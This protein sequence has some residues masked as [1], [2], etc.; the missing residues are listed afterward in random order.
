MPNRGPLRPTDPVS[1][2]I[3]RTIGSTTRPC[4]RTASVI[5]IAPCRPGRRIRRRRSKVA[6]STTTRSGN[7]STTCRQASTGA[8][9]ASSRP[10]APA[11]GRASR[12]VTNR[13]PLRRPVG[14]SPHDSGP[15]PGQWP[16]G[17]A[18]CRP[19]GP[20]TPDEH[21]LGVLMPL[22]SNV[23]SPMRLLRMTHKFLTSFLGAVG[24]MLRSLWICSRSGPDHQHTI[25]E[26]RVTSTEPTRQATATT[27]R[28]INGSGQYQPHH[29]TRWE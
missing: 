9:G 2:S 7:T 18:P 22:L 11:L 29:P 8:T 3:S 1:G 27:M 19:K 17:H 10:S 13:N 26:G 16:A 28:P 20:T 12:A 15:R 21:R 14:Q 5:S 6:V 24:T 23:S 25:Q 4:S